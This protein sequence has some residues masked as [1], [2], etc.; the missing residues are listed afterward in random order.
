MNR[1]VVT[2]LSVSFGGVTAVDNVS[3]VVEPGEIFAIIGPNGAGKSTIFNLLSRFYQPT[4][5]S[6]F[7]GEQDL[8]SK[9]AHE[10]V[11]FGIARTFQNIELFE[12][13]SV[14]QNLL[15]GRHRLARRNALVE[16]LFPPSIRRLEH[17]HRMKVEEIIELLDIQ[18]L[19]YERIRDLPYGARKN[20]EIARALCTE[21][22]LLLLDEP[23]SGLNPEETD[24]LAFWLDDIRS[25]L[26][27]T[28]IMIEHDMGLVNRMADRVL[29]ISNGRPLKLGTPADV[30]DD[31]E[32]Q[33]AYLG[34]QK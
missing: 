12:D 16:M 7:Y 11:R 33:R 9:P 3:F 4:S 15:V 2:D 19:R 21:P 8:L 13:A 1:L 34:V 29:A 23:A 14:L 6:I 17:A 18:H 24:D 30:R 20:V 26:G 27:V 5:G 25:D 28:L 10:I 22:T 32:V 31:P